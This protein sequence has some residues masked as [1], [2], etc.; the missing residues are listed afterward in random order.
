MVLIIDLIDKKMF[1]TAKAGD[2]KRLGFIKACEEENYG[3]R[4]E[5]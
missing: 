1:G 5:L 3:N 2:I 4:K